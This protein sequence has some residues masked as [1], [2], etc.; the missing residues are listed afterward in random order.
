[1]D[2]S[3]C[4]QGLVEASGKTSSDSE[5][6][7]TPSFDQVKDRDWMVESKRGAR[8]VVVHLR[9][10]VGVFLAAL[11]GYAALALRS[12][13]MPFLW[14]FSQAS[15][16]PRERHLIFNLRQASQVTRRPRKFDL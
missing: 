6:L 8:A 4:W 14:H 11:F 1:M 9:V 13:E 3:Q 2:P 10:L 16:S 12:Q 7:K 15:P 5:V